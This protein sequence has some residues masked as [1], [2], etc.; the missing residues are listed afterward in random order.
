MVDGDEALLCK[1]RAG[2]VTGRIGGSN[3][4][5]AGVPWALLLLLLLL[6]SH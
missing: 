4:S 3:G 1:E 6:F 2:V 5:H